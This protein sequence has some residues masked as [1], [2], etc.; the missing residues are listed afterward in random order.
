M[1]VLAVFCKPAS[2]RSVTNTRGRIPALLN[3]F[4]VM[5]LI[6]T[7]WKPS[8][9]V[10]AV[11]E[12]DGRFLMI[13]EHTGAG[14]RLNQPAGHLDPGESLIQAVIRETLEETAHDFEPTALVGIYLAHFVPPST[15]RAEGVT[16]LRVTFT[17]NLGADHQ[18]PLDHGIE[19]VLWMTY[20][21]LVV[22]QARHRSDLVL[23][24]IEDY[25]RGQRSGL[26]LL[27]TQPSIYAANFNMA[28]GDV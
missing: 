7:L 15:S 25:R 12:R 6:S 2:H 13:E 11:I 28:G 4:D 10:A 17:G 20:E 21:E 5:T 14:L 8:V 9:T 19:R 26:D 27:V 24:C 16:Y 3:T 1:L 23:Q 22:N 18:L